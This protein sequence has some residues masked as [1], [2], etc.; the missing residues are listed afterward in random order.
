MM[1]C[2]SALWSNSC[3]FDSRACLIC[4]QHSA[5]GLAVDIKFYFEFD[6]GWDFTNDVLR[7]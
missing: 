2:W 4:K 5:Y 1:D 6:P 7:K 3:W